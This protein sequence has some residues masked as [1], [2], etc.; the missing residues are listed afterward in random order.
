MWLVIVLEA[1]L[2]FILYAFI[3]AFL[4]FKSAGGLKASLSSFARKPVNGIIAIIAVGLILGGLALIGHFLALGGPSKHLEKHLFARGY[5]LYNELQIG[6]LL[7]FAGGLLATIVNAIYRKTKP[8][9]VVAIVVLAILL[10]GTVVGIDI[11]NNSL[12]AATTKRQKA[13]TLAKLNNLPVLYAPPSALD[14]IPDST[15]RPLLVP[16]TDKAAYSLTV[17]FPYAEVVGHFSKDAASYFNPAANLCDI[18]GLIYDRPSGQSG[19]CNIVATINGGLLYTSTQPATFTTRPQ[20]A[21]VKDDAV[22]YIAAG[23]TM[24]Q[25]IDATRSLITVTDQQ[26]ANNFFIY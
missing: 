3:V 22:Y 20:A 6:M 16:F 12:S 18:Q 17:Y 14:N 11:R 4:L 7:L 21:W 15:I 25:L 13:L 5:N 23:D 10:M 26:A 24:Q 2:P 8:R 9:Q 1:S 19:H